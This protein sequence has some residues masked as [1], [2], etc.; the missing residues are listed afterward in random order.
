MAKK[1]FCS[2]LMLTG[3]LLIG[4][5]WGG[6]CGWSGS[7]SGGGHMCCGGGGVGLDNNTIIYA[8]PPIAAPPP[9]SNG[10]APPTDCS[11]LV[12]LIASDPDRTS[13]LYFNAIPP[14]VLILDTTA[15]LGDAIIHAWDG[16]SDPVH[17][18]AVHD[19]ATVTPVFSD[20]EWAKV[21]DL[22]PDRW[23]VAFE[24]LPDPSRSDLDYNDVIITV[25]AVNCQGLSESPPSI[26][27]PIV[28]PAGA[29]KVHVNFL[30]ATFGVGDLYLAS[31][32][33]ELLI[34]KASGNG[35]GASAKNF[36]TGESLVFFL[37]T[38]ARDFSSNDPAVAWVEQ[39]TD[40]NY[41]I[42]YDTDGDNQFD[43]IVHVVL[44]P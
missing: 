6:G 8:P 12:S 42:N 14:G 11:L 28:V 26:S 36:S 35:R 22:R 17:F 27:P 18:I 20:S 5:S 1:F 33:P 9:A 15:N 3:A 37:R 32:P 25:E 21:T 39:I 31:D 16:L 19:G 29:S 38:A 10:G 30:R 4:A 34:D 24:D 23:V 40:K 13:D 43:V 44:T 2:L 7:G 41:R